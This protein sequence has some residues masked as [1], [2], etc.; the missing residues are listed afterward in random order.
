MIDIYFE[1]HDLSTKTE[2]LFLTRGYDKALMWK[3]NA[4][5]RKAIETL[6][7]GTNYNFQLNYF[8]FYMYYYL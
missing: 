3:T 7:Y 1:M 2:Q 5:G 4:R 6:I 8:F